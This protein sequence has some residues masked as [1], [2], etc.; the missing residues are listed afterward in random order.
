MPEW[1]AAEYR[2][3]ILTTHYLVLL[4]IAWETDKNT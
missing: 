2:N 1:D 4:A 3:C